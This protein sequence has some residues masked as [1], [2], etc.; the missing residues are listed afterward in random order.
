VWGSNRGIRER[1]E[2]SG[3]LK[4][5]QDELSILDIYA[6]NIRAFTFIKEALLN[7]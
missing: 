5:Y 4:F 7:S 2:E 3:G 1:T 6:P